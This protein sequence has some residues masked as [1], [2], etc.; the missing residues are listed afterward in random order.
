MDD[1]VTILESFNHAADQALGALGRGVDS[2]E[3]KG[4]LGSRHFDLAVI[5][6]K[7]KWAAWRADI[8]LLRRGTSF[9]CP[10]HIRRCFLPACAIPTF[11][12]GDLPGIG[13]RT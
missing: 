1:S 3:T 4:T 2:D 10:R 5:D 6:A 9:V 11:E 13:L 12:R 7:G 8:P